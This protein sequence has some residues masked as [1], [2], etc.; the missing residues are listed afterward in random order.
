MRLPTKAEFYLEIALKKLKVLA[1]Q[2]HM[3]LSRLKTN[4]IAQDCLSL[5]NQLTFS[6]K[7][8]V[9]RKRRRKRPN[10]RL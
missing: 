10:Q 5:L 2:S 4:L 8:V 1:Q 6:S 3:L 7:R 9:K